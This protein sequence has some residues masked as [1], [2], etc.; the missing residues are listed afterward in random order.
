M[1][2]ESRIS[3]GIS[4]FFGEIAWNCMEESYFAPNTS[5]EMHIQYNSKETVQHT[6]QQ[7]TLQLYFC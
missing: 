2:R 6:A 5:K 7:N 1:Y 4:Y 3:S